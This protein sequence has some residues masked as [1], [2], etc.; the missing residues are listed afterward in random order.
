MKKNKSSPSVMH[1]ISA[2][3]SDDHNLRAPRRN[4][5]LGRTRTSTPCA[6]TSGSHG[7]DESATSCSPIVW[8]PLRCSASPIPE[9]SGPPVARPSMCG[10][11]LCENLLHPCTCTRHSIGLSVSARVL[12]VPGTV[13]ICGEVTDL[14][15]GVFV[16]WEPKSST[17]RLNENS[18]EDYTSAAKL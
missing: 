6:K 7:S 14:Y 15:A 17:K 12:D 2:T 10:F 8:L 5:L 9:T 11:R 13:C 16:R 1:L 4:R 18:K 3:P